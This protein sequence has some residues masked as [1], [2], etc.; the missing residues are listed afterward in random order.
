MYS[1]KNK[2]RT[3]G[4]Y[5]MNVSYQNPKEKTLTFKEFDQ[6]FKEQLVDK[7][8][9]TEKG[10][11]DVGI[12]DIVIRRDGGAIIICEQ[13]KDYERATTSNNAPTT[14]RNYYGSRENGRYAVDHYYE[15]LFLFSIHPD[16]DHHW[17]EILHKKQFSQDDDAAFFLFLFSQNFS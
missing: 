14:T 15:D 12:Q 5:F 11:F 13:L 6:D 17:Q 3:Q 10:L 9:K 8:T 1:E 16:G 2:G 4:Y 7:K